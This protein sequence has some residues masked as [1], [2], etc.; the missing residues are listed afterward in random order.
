[1]Q[2]K[3]K[4]VS[5]REDFWPEPDGTGKRLLGMR[6]EKPIQ[7]TVNPDYT[8]DIYT[9]YLYSFRLNI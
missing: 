1:M 7:V 2:K 3:E 5:D 6:L 8:L 9:R 4:K